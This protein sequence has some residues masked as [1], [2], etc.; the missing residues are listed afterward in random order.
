[1][2][3]RFPGDP[4]RDFSK[5]LEELKVLIDGEC[6]GQRLDQALLHFLTW[7]SRAS[8][9]RLIR[10]G[11]VLLEG[12]EARPARRVRAGDVVRIRIP[13]RPLAQPRP[14]PGDSQIRILFE[15]PYLVA[16]DKPAGM[17]VHPA[18][19]RVHGTLIHYLHRRYRHGVT[20]EDVVPRL[21]HRIDVET[22]GVVA[23]SLHEDFHGMVARQFEAREVRKTYLAVVHGRPSPPDGL[24][25]L[26]IGPD[27]S[28][29][30]RLKLAARRDGSGMPALTRYR[31]VR[32]QRRFSLVELQPKTGRTHQIRVH[33]AALGC[34]VVGDKIYG[35]D[36]RIFLEHLRG[37]LSP[38]SRERLILDRHALHS[39][40]LRYRHPFRDEEM[41]LV[42]E[43]PQDMARLLESP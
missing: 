13:K 36:E 6:V 34:P 40:R 15:D 35:G 37:D 21:L 24:I 31:L 10:E 39:H 22:S 26:G 5:P 4:P 30:V 20:G 38:S 3:P 32:A 42:A 14:S 33:L 9:H 23:A 19:R 7:R 43:L 11:H 12:R 16:V 2:I 17:A 28:S 41:E 27:S 25:D 8:I 29:P 1:L 18:G